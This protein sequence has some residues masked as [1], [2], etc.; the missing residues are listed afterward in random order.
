MQE[1]ALHGWRLHPRQGPHAH[2]WLS[3]QDPLA[4]VVAATANGSPP[5][6]RKPRSSGPSSRRKAR[7]ASRR[8]NAASGPPRSPRRV[9]PQHG[10]VLAVGY[11]DGCILLIRLTDASELLVRPA[12]KTAAA[13]R[14]SPGTRRQAPR[15]RMRG[16]TGR[17]PHASDLRRG[18][19]L[20]ALSSGTPSRPPSRNARPSSASRIGRALRYALARTPPSRSTRSPATTRLVLAP[21]Q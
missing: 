19:M 10:Y 20:S 7:W 14:R 1:N 17:H 18:G 16:R 4:L 5:P 13:S 15:L 8:A 12:V 11:E 3:V 6:A 9:P 21:K 2:E